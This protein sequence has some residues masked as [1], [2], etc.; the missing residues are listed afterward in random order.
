M[1]YISLSQAFAQWQELA[2]DI[3]K[4]DDVM[5][6]ESWNDYTDSLCK[7]GEL[8]AL[9][10]HYAPS[11]G[12][13]M[14]GKGSRYDELS[15]DREFVLEQMGVTLSAVFVPFSQ[16]RNKGE[17]SPSLN[18]RVTL[19]LRDK[20]IIET[21]YMQGSGHCPA[22]KNPI[23]FASGKRDEYLTNK[24]IVREC[25]TG[26]CARNMGSGSPN[27]TVGAPISL[28]DV[29]DVLHCLLSDAL[30]LDCRD[31]ADWCAELSMDSGSIKAR[32]TYD[33]C[34]AESLK[35][36]A[37]FGDKTMAELRELFEGR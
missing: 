3:P 5:L 6:A 17:K 36:R 29:V 20:D 26:K 33:A 28:P 9:Q 7:N 12:D 1:S 8:C 10:Y 37:A 32:N 25:E 21:D 11:Y 18:W 15:D 4:D 31:F 16:S 13:D 22:Y 14:P 2:A 19:K 35:L 24:A 23:K 34:V 30:V 27:F